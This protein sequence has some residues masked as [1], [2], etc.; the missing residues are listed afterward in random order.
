MAE[1]EEGER[2]TFARATMYTMLG[3]T[4][5]AHFLTRE[6]S[7]QLIPFICAEFGFNDQQ[8]GTLL[9][10]YFPG[11][12]LGQLPAAMLAD[13]IGGKRVLSAGMWG[14]VAMMLLMGPTASSIPSAFAVTTVLGFC[15]GPL[16]PVHGI[17][18]RDW[19]PTALGPERAMVLRCTNYGMQI[20]RFLTSILTPIIR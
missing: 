7:P 19:M 12:V 8:R 1:A 16:Y 17:V 2:K 6:M 14:A 15:G 4:S 10:A 18:K 5:A 9:G 13:R 11:Y 20:G 3:F